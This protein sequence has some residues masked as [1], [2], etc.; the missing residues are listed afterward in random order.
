[1]DASSDLSTLGAML[2]RELQTSQDAAAAATRSKEYQSQLSLVAQA[3]GQQ[4][5][6]AKNADTDSLTKLSDV[7]AELSELREMLHEKEA[8]SLTIPR[9]CRP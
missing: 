5:E 2:D 7:F 9:E 3:E 6:A 4:E 8:S 1:M